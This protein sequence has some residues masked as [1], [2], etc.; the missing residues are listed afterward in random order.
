MD[1]NSGRTARAGDDMTPAELRR[2]FFT[3]LRSRLLVVWPILSVLLGIMMA[4]GIAVGLLEHWKLMD[5]IYFAFISG[6]TIG[7]GDLVPKQ[8]LSRI[9][10]VAIGLTGVLLVGLI[11]AVGVSA[12]DRASE[13][14][15]ERR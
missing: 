7:Y 6:L 10:A 15:G 3:E 5:A 11:V 14:R 13:H 12:L 2:F 4:L 9:L 1:T 8:P